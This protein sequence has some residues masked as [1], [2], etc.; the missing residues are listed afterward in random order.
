MA[1]D[2]KTRTIDAVTRLCFYQD[3]LGATWSRFVRQVAGKDTNTELEATDSLLS[4]LAESEVAPPTLIT[5]IQESLQAPTPLVRPAFLARSLLSSTHSSLPIPTVET[6]FSIVNLVQRQS[7]PVEPYLSASR[8]ETAQGLVN[9]I[10]NILSRLVS[11]NGASQTE[12]IHWTLNFLDQQCRSLSSKTLKDQAL[13]TACTT[14]VER[15]LDSNAFT[16]DQPSGAIRA[17]TEPLTSLLA[18]LSS[19]GNKRRPVPKLSNSAGGPDFS[20][21]VSALVRTS[22]P[23]SPVIDREVTLI[24]ER[25]QY[26]TS[27]RTIRTDFPERLSAIVQYRQQQAGFFSITKEEASTEAFSH[28]LEAAIEEYDRLDTTRDEHVRKSVLA[29]KLPQ[30][31]A[32]MIQTDE[33]LRSALSHAVQIMGTKKSENG[34]EIDS[35]SENRNAATQELTAALCRQG[36]I[37]QDIAFSVDRAIP[38]SQLQT[39]SVSSFDLQSR[40]TTHDSD[41]LKQTLASLSTDLSTQAALASSIC[42][43]VSSHAQSSDLDALA[44]FCDA[45]I[46][47]SSTLEVVFAHEEPRK[48]LVPIRETLDS[49]DTAQD[50]FGESNLIERYGNLVVVVEIVVHRFGLI[51][52]LSYHLGSSRSFLSSWIPS[53]STAYNLSALDEEGRTAVAG[54]IAALFGDGISDDLMHATNPRTLLRIAPTIL[55]QSLV[56]CQDGVVDLD[57]LKDALSYFLQELL[58]FTLPGV[59]QWLMGEIERTPPSPAQNAMF[60]ILQIILFAE[61]L[62]QTVLELVSLDVANLISSNPSLTSTN[63]P[64]FDAVKAKKLVL[65]LRGPRRL[66]SSIGE[67]SAS[68]SEQLSQNLDKLVRDSTADTTTYIA[69][70]R[71]ATSRLLQQHSPDR[72]T[73]LILSR[74]LSLAPTLPDPLPRTITLQ[75]EQKIIAW[76]RV[77]RTGS[78]LFSEFP[79]LL[80]SLVNQVLPTFLSNPSFLQPAKDPL[81]KNKVEMLSDIL[82][83]SFTLSLA[84]AREKEKAGVVLQLDRLAADLASLKS[85][86]IAGSKE[87]DLDA[88]LLASVFISRLTSYDTLSAASKSFSRLSSPSL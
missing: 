48:I 2:P 86:A 57:S 16:K 53:S 46:Q 43:V 76:T 6:I 14:K 85:K 13:L 87:E 4:L 75:V 71:Q 26:S 68:W 82:G 21:F 61:S 65:G 58:S 20:F 50:N 12:T 36:L 80:N 72:I 3:T 52:N 79:S 63:P 59:L 42:E 27:P 10:D 15:I 56:A 78:A 33:L 19:N 8:E 5:F 28:L 34:M 62:P 45:L 35:D 38:T 77:E 83:G 29:V 40:L 25:K 44:H 49:L 18:K 60:D 73:L 31:I 54:F 23:S 67:P 70:I 37:S 81:E 1:I 9:L 64:S 88:P 11:T 24:T 74:L 39:S 47:D 30:V 84:K 32:A 41:E 17:V 66:R 51:D 69:S 22:L 55:K 7:S